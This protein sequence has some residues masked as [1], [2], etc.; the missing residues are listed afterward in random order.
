MPAGSYPEGS[1][2]YGI[3]DMA[4]NVWEWCSDWYDETYYG[5]KTFDNPTGPPSGKGRV[6]RGGSWNNDARACRCSN[7]NSFP[8]ENRNYILGFRCVK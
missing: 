4:G 6:I 5:N 1:S 8:P 7:R 3:M 2:P